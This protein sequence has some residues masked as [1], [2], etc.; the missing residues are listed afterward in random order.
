MDHKPSQCPICGEKES[1]LFSVP[2]DYRKPT[3]SKE[4]H[5]N[6]CNICHYGEV[7]DRPSKDEVPG[8][9]HLDDYYTHSK[10]TRPPEKNPSFLEKLRTFISW[11]LDTGSEYS[12]EELNP[13][14]KTDNPSVLEI[15][16][17]NGEGLSKLLEAGF[18]V[19]GVEPDPSARAAAKKLVPHI[20]EGTAEDLPEE[21]THQ[22]YDVIIMIHVLE[23]CLD[24]NLAVSNLSKLLKPGGI[25][26]VETP[27]SQAFAFKDYQGVWP[28]TDIP[29]HLNFFTPSSLASILNKHEFNV[30]STKYFGFCRQFSK[31]WLKVEE[32]VWE[33]FSKNSPQGKRPHFSLRSWGL[34][35]RSVFAPKAS[36]Y[37]SVR[38]IGI[39]K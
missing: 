15:G 30:I 14:L 36:K 12:I 21:V 5:V 23:H 17:G 20:F 34:L 29:R 6:W 1:F 31:S 11:R 7:L 39:K 18:S 28:W 24:I 13:L 2:C 32:N 19:S 16:C 8:F 38:L 25:Y 9:Y 4:Y 22:T 35:L 37:D 10:S 33:A 26:L 27:N 3:K